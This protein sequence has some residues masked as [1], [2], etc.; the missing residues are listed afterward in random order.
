LLT[1][2]AVAIIR[3]MRSAVKATERD[4]RISQ[5]LWR[6]WPRERWVP[7][8]DLTC[9]NW[10]SYFGIYE[11]H[12]GLFPPINWIRPKF[13]ITTLY[14]ARGV[15]KDLFWKSPDQVIY[16][17]NDS[18]SQDECDR[19]ATRISQSAF[20]YD[21]AKELMLDYLFNFRDYRCWGK[22]CLTRLDF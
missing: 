3:L 13:P 19:K 11:P 10:C 22:N 14:G 1:S 21:D 17:G 2:P 18:I 20:D 8:P 15:C 4:I 7:E 9:D 5:T 16:S 6:Y 12:P